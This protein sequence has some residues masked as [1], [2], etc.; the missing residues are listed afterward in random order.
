M[1]PDENIPQLKKLMKIIPV[2]KVTNVCCN[3][4]GKREEELL[5]KGSGK[6][7]RQT[8]IYVSKTMSNTNNRDIGD[9]LE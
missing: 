7:E 8:V 5:K 2:E 1:K 9:I 3:Y 4:Y 6:M